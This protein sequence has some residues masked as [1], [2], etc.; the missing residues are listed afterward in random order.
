[1]KNVGILGGTFDIVHNGHLE[2]AT[3]VAEL[4]GL[5]K[6]FLVTAGQPPHKLSQVS[7]SEFRHE[8][9]VVAVADLP[10]LEASRIELDRPGLS[11]T[12]NTVV[13]LKSQLSASAGE[14]V[15]I[16]FI[17]SAEYL[18]P[19]NPSNVTTWEE[20]EAFL[21]L[22]NLVVVPRGQ[23]TAELARGWASQLNLDNVRILEQAVSPLSSGVVRDAL[24]QGHSIDTLVPA[25]VAELVK[26]RGLCY[27]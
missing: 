23:Y 9:V 26:Q 1:M 12:Y 25:K 19:S 6:V 21:Q 17:L 18:D 7:D 27:R 22:V 14:E 4:L 13:E 5:E 20:A 11:Y 2:V 8:L 24:R 3:V 10:H 16:N 15:N